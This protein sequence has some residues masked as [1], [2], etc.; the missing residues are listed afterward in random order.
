MN[1]T[2]GFQN[3][4]LALDVRAGLIGIQLNEVKKMAKVQIFGLNENPL[5]TMDKAESHREIR[6]AVDKGLAPPHKQEHGAILFLRK[7]NRVFTS[8]RDFEASAN[9]DMTDKSIGGHVLENQTVETALLAS[10]I[11]EFNIPLAIVSQAE[12]FYLQVHHPTLFEKQGFASFV[13]YNPNY[14]SI[15]TDTSGESWPELSRQHFYLGAYNGPK[16]DDGELGSRP[17]TLEKLLR[18]I[19]TNEEKV[20][21][22]LKHIVTKYKEKI[23]QIMEMQE[24]AIP[25][26]E[27][28]LIDIV[29]LTE[30]PMGT[31]ERKPVH[32]PMIEAH[33]QGKPQPYKHPHICGIYLSPEGEILVQDRALDKAENPGL[34]DKP[35]GGHIGTGD[36]PRIAAYHESITE[37]G[38]PI[39]IFENDVWANILTNFPEATRFQAICQVP[40]E[41]KN[42]VSYR[43]RADGR[44]FPETC[45]QWFTFGYYNGPL[46]F[47]DKEATGA[48]TYKSWEALRDEIK[49]N[50]DQFTSDLKYVVEHF[51]DK[52]VPL[53]VALQQQAYISQT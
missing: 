17:F 31:R 41:V 36:T 34:K 43:N 4:K 9:P 40:F 51:R 14:T 53:E 20:T 44:S 7:G 52:L 23:D 29:S 32:E 49:R 18:Y 13:D 45:D 19:E 37:M 42:Y 1:G 38:I 35:W 25:E 12:L 47:L 24:K 10:S 3:L 2:Q 39:G 5:G 28:E 26:S 50:P 11:R 22:D 27:S 30:D 46:D 6:E 21:H 15:R 48:Y 8:V 16:N 33:A